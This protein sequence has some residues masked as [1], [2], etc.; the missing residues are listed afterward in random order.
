MPVVIIRCQWG[1]HMVR[2]VRLGSIEAQ[3][4]DKPFG[5]FWDRVE[6]GKWEPTTISV[7]QQEARGTTYIDIGGWIG[8]TVLA[9]AP[10]AEKVIVYEPDPV[11]LDL[12]KT[13]IRLN[14]LSNV[15]LRECALYD[16]NGQVPFGPGMTAKL[17]QSESSL[18]IGEASTSVTAVDARDEIERPEFASCDLMK[19]DVEGAE[20]VLVPHMSSYFARHRPVLLLSLHHVDWPSGLP[21]RRLSAAHSRLREAMLRL[22]LLWVLRGYRYVWAEVRDGVYER[23]D[24]WDCLSLRA[25][26]KLVFGQDNWEL[27]FSDRIL[28]GAE[29][30]TEA[31]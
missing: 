13:H 30:G 9:G 24:F 5:Y 2:T 15:E 29:R 4:S 27:L 26:F 6:V 19:I 11:A 8:P 28:S 22:R 7:I 21:G 20:F 16:R 31:R 18:V 3:V 12:L 23:A 10:F 17:G 1:I 25:R 14:D